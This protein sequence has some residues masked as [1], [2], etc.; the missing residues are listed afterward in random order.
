MEFNSHQL[1][2]APPLA[3][4]PD[5]ISFH[6][7]FR[8]VSFGPISGA[9]RFRSLCGLPLRDL[10]ESRMFCQLPEV[11]RAIATAISLATKQQALYLN[12]KL[13]W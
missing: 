2:G 1:T 6:C 13:H 11:P 12:H 8:V 3:F 5:D 7:S 9:L 10:L 4:K